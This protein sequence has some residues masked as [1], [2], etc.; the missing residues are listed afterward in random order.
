MSPVD[1]QL[2][3][4]LPTQTQELEKQAVAEGFRF[5]TRLIEEWRTGTNRFDAQGE[6][7]MAA[8]LGDRLVGIGGLTCDPFTQENIG[9]LR[10]VYI[11][12]EARGQNIGKTLV[13]RLVEHA[14]QHFR[15]VRLS[16][17]TSDA[18]AFYL[19]CGFQPMDDDHATH[20][21]FLGNA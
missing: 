14:T 17:D 21:M 2:I 13:D 3:T 5:L 18:D 8:Y 15:I 12:R 7:L 4:T 20:G 16:T 10:R 6:C 1:I 11:A 9:R 19:R